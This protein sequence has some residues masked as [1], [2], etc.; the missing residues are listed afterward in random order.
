MTDENKETP[1]AATPEVTVN[2]SGE[3]YY[4]AQEVDNLL[5]LVAS[6]IDNIQLNVTSKRFDTS[7]GN[8]RFIGPLQSKLN[9]LVCANRAITK[10]I[11][12]LGELAMKLRRNR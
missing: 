6:S 7:D 2:L 4:T 11:D 8:R 5:R 3:Q 9:Q 12:T 10:F 1:G